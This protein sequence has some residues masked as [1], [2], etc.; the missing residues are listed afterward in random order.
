MD[1]GSAAAPGCAEGSCGT[2]TPARAFFLAVSVARLP[3]HRLPI[4]HLANHHPVTPPPP[5]PCLRCCKQKSSAIRPNGHPTVYQRIN[6]SA[7]LLILWAI[8]AF[9]GKKQF[10][11]L[12]KIVLTSAWADM[13]PTATRPQLRG[14]YYN[15]FCSPSLA[16][17][18]TVA[19]S[20]LRF[21][22]V[23]FLGSTTHLGMFRLR[24]GELF[25]RPC[26]QHDKAQENLSPTMPH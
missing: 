16:R 11:Q 18:S 6:F 2:D 3:C 4:N 10:P 15:L 9:C 22:L 5:L 7:N 21:P 24:A 23:S 20:P 17:K 19:E 1:F 26:A 25:A 14:S 13:G 12:S 8:S